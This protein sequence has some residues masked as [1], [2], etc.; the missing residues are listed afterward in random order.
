MVIVW[1]AAALS[2]MKTEAPGTI[3]TLSPG[4]GTTPPAHVAG[5]FHGPPVA[6]DVIEAKLSET[7]ETRVVTPFTATKRPCACRLVH[8]KINI[9]ESNQPRRL[10][11]HHPPPH[12]QC[13]VSPHVFPHPCII[14]F[15]NLTA[16]I[17]SQTWF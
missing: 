9:K 6:V 4:P 14:G 10:K 8:A 13:F 5:S 11:I 1:Q 17:R 16:C 3:T 2:S 15:I 12:R 7:G